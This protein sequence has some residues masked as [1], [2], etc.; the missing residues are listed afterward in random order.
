M[1]LLVY[2]ND[3]SK[4]TLFPGEVQYQTREVGLTARA[5]IPHFIYTHALLINAR[6]ERY[7]PLVDMTQNL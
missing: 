6:G 7:L 1:R 5:L 3:C 4:N 2:M